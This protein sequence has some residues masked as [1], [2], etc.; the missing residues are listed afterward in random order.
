MR[1]EQ[2]MAAI[3]VELKLKCHFQTGRSSSN[4]QMVVATSGSVAR[5]KFEV[6]L[7]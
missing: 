4:P 6:N 1:F 7:G 2:A 3:E 5:M